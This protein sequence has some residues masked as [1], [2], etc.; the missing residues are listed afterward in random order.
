MFRGMPSAL[1]LSSTK[2]EEDKDDVEIASKV[3]LCPVRRPPQRPSESTVTNIQFFSHGSRASFAL[4]LA[5][6][7]S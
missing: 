3:A 5:I 1:D 4:E 7:I 6:I 2:H